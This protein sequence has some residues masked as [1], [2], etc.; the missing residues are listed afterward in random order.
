MSTNEVDDEA[1]VG[2]TAGGTTEEFGAVGRAI[3]GVEE[4]VLGE[5]GG[6]VAGVGVG[7]SEAED[8][9]VWPPPAG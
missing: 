5:D 8:G 4:V 2:A 3:D 7:V 1:A 6:V 9:A